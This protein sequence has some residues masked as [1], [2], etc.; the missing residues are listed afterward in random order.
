M[1]RSLTRL[2]LLTSTLTVSAFQAALSRTTGPRRDECSC[3]QFNSSIVQQF[4]FSPP[5]PLTPSPLQ[6]LTT[7]G[8]FKEHPAWSPDGSLIAF[9]VYLKG[10]VGLVA[11][12]PGAAEWKHITPLDEN[13][14]REPAWSPDGKRI[15]FVHDSLSGTDG[16]LELHLMNADGSDSKRLVTP[17]KRPAQDE[18]PAWSPDGKTIAFTTTRDGNQEIYLCDADGGNLRRITTHKAIDS[19]PTWSPDGRQIA[20]CS[21]RFGNMEICV[22]NADGSDVRRLTDHPALDYAPKWSPDGQHIAFTSTR[23]RNYEVYLIRPDGTGLRNLTQHPD[24]DKDPAWTPDSSRV[25]FVSNRGGRFDLY[26]IEI[27]P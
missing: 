14:E 22:M 8:N 17:A 7:D 26:S 6:R 27:A 9:T 18:H 1:N 15:L 3:L 4:N 20:F 23:D 19:H 13:P 12:A 5:H 21:A 11:M 24:L 25:T 10:K 16:Q 2:V